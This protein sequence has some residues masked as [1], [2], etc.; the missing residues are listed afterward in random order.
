MQQPGCVEGEALATLVV[1][2]ILGIVKVALYRIR[3]KFARQVQETAPGLELP[4]EMGTVIRKFQHRAQVASA[5]G[6][7]P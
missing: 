7:G 5:G 4:A 2:T 6:H 3:R 1:N